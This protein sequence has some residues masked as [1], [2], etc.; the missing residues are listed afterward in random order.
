[1]EDDSD[2]MLIAKWLN[3]Q[4]YMGDYQET[5][6]RSADELKRD[7]II[8][9][10]WKLFIIIKKNNGRKIGTVNAQMVKPRIW[11]IG[12]ALVPAERGKG[13]GAEALQIILDHLFQTADAVRIQAHTDVKNTASGKALTK[14]GFTKEATMR[15]LGYCRG[16]YGDEYLYRIL[17]EEWKEPKILTKTAQ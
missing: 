4:E 3:D 8:H 7:M 2:I 9:A 17:R 11:E 1:M 13:Y 6:Q 12:F 5:K 15:K 16:M 10:N 14:S